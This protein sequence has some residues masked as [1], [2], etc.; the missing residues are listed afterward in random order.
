MTAESS[1]NAGE[2]LPKRRR[3][4]RSRS[5]VP[6]SS[7]V[8][9]SLRNIRLGSVVRT[10]RIARNT[11]K[12]SVRSTWLMTLPLWA[13]VL[14]AETDFLVLLNVN[15]ISTGLFFTDQPVEVVD[16]RRPAAESVKKIVQALIYLLVLGLSVFHW[17]AIYRYFSS[18][19]HWIVIVAYLFAGVLYSEEPTK[20]ITNS[21]L[22]SIGLLIAVLFSH[23]QSVY[24][25][26]RNL[27]LAVFVPMFFLHI[28]S[29]VL[30]FMYEPNIFGFLASGRRYGG[31]AGSP[32]TLGGSA[33][34]GTWAAACI[35]FDKTVVGILRRFAIVG[36]MVFAFSIIVSGSGTALATILLMSSILLW[37]RM[38][39]S[40]K[41]LVR[42]LLNGFVVSVVAM[43][44]LG[45]MIFFTP[46]E[47]LV[48]FTD[49]L[50]KDV[51]LTGR[52][53]LWEIA[54]DAISAKPYM[55][56]GFDS[57][58]TVK[59]YS[60]YWIDHNHYHNGYLDVLLAG[61]WILFG[62]VCYNLGRFLFVFNRA[63]KREAK[64]FPLIMPFVILTVLNLSEYSLL[65]PLSPQWQIYVTIF[66][67]LTFMPVEDRASR[68]VA[69]SSRRGRRKRSGKG[70][71]MRW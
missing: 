67:M 26:Y 41:P 59:S 39:A 55:G 12:F 24:T 58:G 3:R 16:G 42:M 43:T 15:N 50:D 11:F 34:F 45:V 36:L 1:T 6:A 13:I 65:R 62:L 14:S 33:V 2:L 47:L 46:T 57:H 17:R 20:V 54:A 53:L 70:R 69:A 51:T 21:I 48:Y 64:A 9:G 60:A 28:C 68:P 5:D 44:V 56:W 10:W 61:G 31:M 52:T 38:L 19:P 27:Y 71:A 7:R 66:V 25:R 29:V 8:A 32:N 18:N 4:S 37:M 35:F 40:V 22:I 49:S 30:L 63:F 23:G